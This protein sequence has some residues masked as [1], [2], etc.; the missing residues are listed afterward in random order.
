VHH[1]EGELSAE[2]SS[3]EDYP[4]HH[5]T[6]SVKSG[7]RQSPPLEVEIQIDKIPLTME[8]DTG[9]A[10]TLVSET[11][12]NQF[13]K[14]EL[15]PSQVRLTAYSGDEI[16]VI[17]ST[18]VCVNYGS[19]V[20]TLPLLVVKGEGPSLLGRNWLRDQT[21][22]AVYSHGDVGLVEKGVG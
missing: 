3:S 13:W 19:Q 17:G 7:T 5:I 16:P 20:A 21:R 12:F 10:Y 1:L 11:T 8:L 9:A 6:A 14:R 18:E 15:Q 4:L 22:L 2:G